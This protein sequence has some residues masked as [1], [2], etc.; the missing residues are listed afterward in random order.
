MPLQPFGETLLRVLHSVEEFHVTEGAPCAPEVIDFMNLR[1]HGI[2]WSPLLSCAWDFEFK[3]K[4]NKIA[5][6]DLTLDAEHARGM[7]VGKTYAS[8]ALPSVE[9]RIG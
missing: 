5:T 4:A 1:R 2:E 7:E 8:T 3:G 6:F 9:G